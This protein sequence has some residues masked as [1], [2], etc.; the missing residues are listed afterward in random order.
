[1][2]H[3]FYLVV[4][5]SYN[6]LHFNRILLYICTYRRYHPIF[7]GGEGALPM[8]KK[9]LIALTFFLLNNQL[10]QSTSPYIAFRSQSR[11]KVRQV[12]GSVNNIHLSD[13]ESWWGSAWITTEYT[14]SFRPNS[15][16]RCLFDDDVI[17]SGLCSFTN[18]NTCN[19]V[20]CPT[21]ITPFDQDCDASFDR[22]T[23]LVQGSQV[24]NRNQRAWLADYFYLP[25]DFNSALNFSPKISN[26]IVDFDLYFGFDEWICGAYFF[27][28]GPF[29]HTRWNLD[30]CETF[31]VRGTLPDTPGYFNPSGIIANNLLPNFTAYARGESISSVDDIIFNSLNFARI[32]NCGHSKDGFAELRLE[33][34]WDFFQS[35]C[36]HLGINVQA[37]A[38]T[39][40]RPNALFLFNPVVGNGKHWEVGAGM[41]GHYT[42]WTSDIEDKSFG[43]YFDANVTHLFKTRQQRTFDL[44]CKPNS[45]YMLAERLGTPITS[46]LQGASV[47]LPELVAGQGT[48]PSAQFK[49]EYTPV[50]NLTTLDAQV[51]IGA[52]ADIVAFFNYSSCGFSWDLGY[53]FWG[54][55]C[56]KI[57]PSACS[58]DRS[59]PPVISSLCTP[60]QENVWALK[61]DMRIF[62]FSSNGDS[63]P[64]NTPVPL[65]ATESMATIHGGTN[66]ISTNSNPTTNPGVDHPLFAYADS[67]A[68]PFRVLVNPNDP[69]SSTNHIMTSVD[70][71]FINCCDID[72]KG[73]RGISHKIFT[74]FSYNFECDSWHPYVGVGG[75][76]EFGKR[77]RLQCNE[78]LCVSS[79]V[80][81][82]SSNAGGCGARGCNNS[83][84]HCENCALSQWGLWIKSGISFN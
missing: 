78:S 80:S 49:N 23:I 76:A 74:H 65:S 83:K 48:V 3:S 47:T 1:M 30:F 10:V 52:Q 57:H 38:P 28:Y 71:V 59:C 64:I 79:C 16:I 75:F 35:Q 37:A 61:G 60:G 43:F 73:T 63:T 54:R 22:R 18:F 4:Q 58:H 40:T 66:F 8:Y 20:C 41:T 15:I 19:T 72:F 53:N 21:V 69:N 56:E 14:R 2:T 6:L 24:S 12:V 50:A 9:I 11:D 70:P 62:G 34:G 5:I 17:N 55:S 39:G 45:R 42:I 84:D 31:S 46:N 81:A 44:R 82:C 13:M 27:A 68:T 51:S 33:L 67:V 32:D 26:V 7:F 36:Y 29:V 25:P 77:N